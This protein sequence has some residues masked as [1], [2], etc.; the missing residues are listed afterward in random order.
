[1]TPTTTGLT[2]VARRAPFRCSPEHAAVAPRGAAAGELIVGFEPGGCRLPETQQRVVAHWVRGWLAVQP[3]GVL[4]MAHDVGASPD[5]RLARLR[6][7]SDAIE[8]LGVPRDNLK[9]TDLPVH[10]LREG[11][12]DGPKAEDAV[13]LSWFDPAATPRSVASCGTDGMSAD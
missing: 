4:V 9:Y 13:L 7:L 6:A 12:G 8:R 1:M 11:G 5:T 10:A 3:Q 2:G